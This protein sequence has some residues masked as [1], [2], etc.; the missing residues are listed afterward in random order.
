MV[1]FIHEMVRSQQL[2]SHL[3]NNSNRLKE[4]SFFFSFKIPTIPFSWTI[5]LMTRSASLMVE[6][7]WTPPLSFCILHGILCDACKILLYR[8]STLERNRAGSL[9]EAVNSFELAAC[10]VSSRC[11]GASLEHLKSPHRAPW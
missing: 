5:Y 2:H 8:H 9:V 3:K 11:G 6:S 4:N 1:A 7:D 10:V